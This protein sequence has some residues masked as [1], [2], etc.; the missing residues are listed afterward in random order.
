MLTRVAMG[1]W[2]GLSLGVM[3]AQAG[4]L[5]V[6][7]AAAMKTALTQIA[8][9]FTRQTGDT[10]R[11]AFGTAGFIRDKAAGGEAFDVAVVPPAPLGDLVRRGLVSGGTEVQLALVRIGAAV[12]SG[13]P[14]PAIATVD[15]FKA[16]VL[17]APSIGMADPASGATSGIFLAKM[18][19]QLGV[20]EQVRP[21]LKLYPE[22]QTAMEAG[23]RGEVALGLGQISE[24]TPVAGMD[25]LGPIPDALQ[26]RT[27]YAAGLAKQSHA[28]E[29]ALRLLAFLRGPE[30]AAAMAAQGFEAP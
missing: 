13:T 24:I 8:P 14:H 2:V 1:V 22:G 12:R 26:L 11:F 29:A 21:K 17:A 10:L 5:V 19:E 30:A 18:L 28:P 6:F 9:E 27:I 16:T 4:E 7:S 25:M 15:E 3:P 23:A 20:I